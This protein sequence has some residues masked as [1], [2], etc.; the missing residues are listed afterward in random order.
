M[1]RAVT[2][3][4]FEFNDVRTS[5]SK[6]VEYFSGPI[7]KLEYQVYTI[8]TTCLY[9]PDTE[10]SC[11][12]CVKESNVLVLVNTSFYYAKK[13]VII[14][15]T[16]L[17]FIRCTHNNTL[18]SVLLCQICSHDQFCIHILTNLYYEI[19][20]RRM[21]IFVRFVTALD[22]VCLFVLKRKKQLELPRPSG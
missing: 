22:L 9:P 1:V 19:R 6:F 17:N 12:A 13:V 21:Q 20:I 14:G 10:T 5:D 15:I 2:K 3:F 18:H 16:F 7:V 11:V 8:G 4:A